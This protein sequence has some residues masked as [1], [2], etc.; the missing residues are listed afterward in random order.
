M[1]WLLLPS[2][3]WLQLP[4]LAPGGEQDGQHEITWFVGLRESEAWGTHVS[5][6][7][8]C[9]AMGVACMGQLVGGADSMVGDL[10]PGDPGCSEVGQPWSNG[11]F[12]PSNLCALVEQGSLAQRGKM[13][14]RHA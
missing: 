3:F 9:S 1:L 2:L 13:E 10:N 12:W 7:A 8:Q 6:M 5:H 4:A 14:P 11:H